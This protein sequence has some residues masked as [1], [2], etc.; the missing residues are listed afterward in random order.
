MAHSSTKYMAFIVF[1]DVSQKVVMARRIGKIELK[2]I[3]IGNVVEN[4]G[5]GTESEKWL[6]M[7]RQLCAI[8]KRAECWCRFLFQVHLVADAVQGEMKIRSDHGRKTL[9]RRSG[10]CL[11]SWHHE[12][13]TSH[14]MCETSWKFLVNVSQAQAEVEARI[15]NRDQASFKMAF[16]TA[17]LRAAQ[18]TRVVP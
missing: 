6:L 9:L 5:N 17:N 2:L 15:E 4:R 8:I 7:L 10:S 18:L 13:Q 11:R 12:W 3:G 14:E 1:V 16:E